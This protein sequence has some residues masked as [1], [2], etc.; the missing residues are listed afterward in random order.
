MDSR[1]IKIKQD[2]FLNYFLILSSFFLILGIILFFYN[3]NKGFD[4]TDE[5][6]YF[7]RLEGGSYKYSFTNFSEILRPLYLLLNKDIVLL[8][9]S[10]II[11][12]F[13]LGYLLITQVFEKLNLSDYLFKDNKLLKNIFFLVIS[14]ISLF[15]ILQIKLYTP[16]YNNLCFFGL[17]ISSLA[18]IRIYNSRNNSFFDFLFLSLSI[19]LLFLSKPPACFIL[20]FSIFL[21]S[22]FT[23]KKLK[24][25]I[26]SVLIGLI[27]GILS[28]S[29]FHDIQ[30]INLLNTYKNIYGI[31]QLTESTNSFSY[32][33]KDT[34]FL[35]IDCFLNLSYILYWTLF[36]LNIYFD[37][38]FISK[39]FRI[40]FWFSKLYLISPIFTILLF[41]DKVIFLISLFFALP[42]SLL[43]CYLILYK[44]IINKNKFILFLTILLMPYF[45]TLGTNNQY[46]YTSS[47][48]PIFFVISSF[49]LISELLINRSSILT[50]KLERLLVVFSILSTI[51]FFNFLSTFNMNPYRQEPNLFSYKN[52][53]LIGGNTELKVSNSA[54][55]YLSESYNNIKK[56]N[57]KNN[58]LILDLT[59]RSPG[60]IFAM[61]GKPL[62]APWI[63]GGYPVSN[64]VFLN[65]LEK[66]N[67]EELRNSWILTE[68]GTART[69][70]E[71]LLK[72]KGI[73]LNND[74]QYKLVM[75]IDSSQINPKFGYK[76]FQ[77]LYKPLKKNAI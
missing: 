10:N 33:F 11:I 29:K 36:Y 51:I 74:E 65:K 24:V 13:V 19:Y 31:L 4:F 25:Q 46:I 7:N 76:S 44:K 30:I 21:G 8:R 52:S 57:F 17:V 53:F 12:S 28:L 27:I 37:N 69:L 40:V 41:R 55:K 49:I 1:N 56:N 42:I 18:L 39:K 23:N 32:M 71:N 60:F 6:Y 61:G 15:E 58:Q 73:Y 20:I 16:S 77:Y 66:V 75:K 70:D 5:G 3:A 2:K 22:I 43:I 64:K 67:I 63:L 72:T 59:G 50:R 48:V 35:V 26:F 47:R 9:Q 14:S 38:N 45:Y 62:I 54:Y 34:F 68:P